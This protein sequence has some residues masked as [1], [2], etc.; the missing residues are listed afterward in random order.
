MSL[1]LALLLACQYVAVLVVHCHVAD[2]RG[3]ADFAHFRCVS[4]IETKVD[5]LPSEAVILCVAAIAPVA[6]ASS[7]ALLLPA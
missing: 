4:S 3:Y 6:A 5:H 2:R 1:F 7:E